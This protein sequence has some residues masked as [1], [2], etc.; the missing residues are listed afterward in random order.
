MIKSKGKEKYS[1][2]IKKKK[3]NESLYDQ[4]KDQY[5]ILHYAFH[6]NDIIVSIEIN[7]RQRGTSCSS[8]Y[9]MVTKATR[10]RENK[11]KG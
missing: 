1:S 6:A 7:V 2:L 9:V 8:M 5:S 4:K 10:L 3:I 11:D